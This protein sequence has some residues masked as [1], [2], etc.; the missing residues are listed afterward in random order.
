[1]TPREFS[2]S[3]RRSYEL[4][5][6]LGVTRSLRNE[7][8]LDSDKDFNSIALD[9]TVPYPEVFMA[10]LKL[11]HYN[12][13]LADYSV[14]QFSNATNLDTRLCFYPSPFGP[15]EFAAV[16][17]LTKT[18]DKGEIDFEAYC[19]FLES[20]PFNSRRPLLRFEYS[21]DQYVRG[22]HPAAHLHI[23]TYGEDRWPCERKMTPFAFSAMVAKLYFSEHWE[24]ITEIENDESRKNTFD[25][26]YF[27]EK[28]LCQ[29]TKVEYFSEHERQQFHLA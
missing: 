21:E 12:F 17:T 9:T 1:M 19:Y 2:I 15:H 22:S 24:A 25:E 7:Q 3:I 27:A 23:G 4:F 29:I 18:L 10:A 13:Q 11:G 28:K 16:Q 5:S 8:P 20:L 6:D 14:F 26:S